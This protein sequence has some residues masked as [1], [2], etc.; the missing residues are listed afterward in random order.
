MITYTIFSDGEVNFPLGVIDEHANLL[1]GVDA[2]NIIFAEIKRGSESDKANNLLC[3][4]DTE[5]PEVKDVITLGGLMGK[6]SRP[7]D[8]TRVNNLLNRIPRNELD[9]HTGYTHKTIDEIKEVEEP[10]IEGEKDLSKPVIKSGNRYKSKV[11]WTSEKVRKK[12][13]R[14]LANGRTLSYIARCLK[15]SRSTLTKANERHYQD[16]YDPDYSKAR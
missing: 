5:H 15:V 6:P 11:D 12:I 3:V 8:N 13:K 4:L 2:L 16:L 9:E 14:E 7:I 1:S 10:E